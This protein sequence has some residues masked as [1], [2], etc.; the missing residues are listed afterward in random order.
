M[1]DFK[2]KYM[3]STW[4]KQSEVVNEPENGFP[5]EIT[6]PSMLFFLLFAALQY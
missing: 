1:L 5:I 4:M 6:A 3:D 2:C